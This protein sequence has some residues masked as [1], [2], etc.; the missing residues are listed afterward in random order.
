M[1]ERENELGKQRERTQYGIL[2]TRGL[3][4]G[5]QL[6]KRGCVETR[7][8]HNIGCTFITA[9]LVCSS[10]TFLREA[11]C[12]ERRERISGT[13]AGP[14]GPSWYILQITARRTTRCIPQ[15]G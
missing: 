11:Y 10:T 1:N 7:M 8:C 4:D 13:E 3:E 12:P 9:H 6:K 5:F 14:L 15:L 2:Y